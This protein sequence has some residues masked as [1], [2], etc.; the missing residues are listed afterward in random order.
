MY[1]LDL[2]KAAVKFLENLQPKQY[3]QIV[4]TI[5]GLL[6]NPQP[7]DSETLTGS[8]DYRRVDTGEYRIIYRMEK[9][10]VKIAV[11]GKRNDSE[12]YKRFKSK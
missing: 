8:T 12:I 2:T 11:V 7:H 4:K 10:T 5:F 1:K 3:W 6:E 9:D